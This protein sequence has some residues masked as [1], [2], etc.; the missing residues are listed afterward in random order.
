MSKRRN[1]L[2]M[3]RRSRQAVH[4]LCGGQGCRGCEGGAVDV[5]DEFS[6]EYPEDED[7]VVEPPVPMAVLVRQ[8]AA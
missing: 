1:L 5:L 8:E 3:T 6:D 2:T 4:R 7:T